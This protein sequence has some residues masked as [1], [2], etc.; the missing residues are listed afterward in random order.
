MTCCYCESDYENV[1]S[2]EEDGEC[3]Y[4]SEHGEQTET[5]SVDNHRRELPIAALVLEALVLTQLV[6]D[7]SQLAE[8]ALEQAD[9]RRPSA[10][11]RTTW[12]PVHHSAGRRLTTVYE[13]S[14]SWRA[15]TS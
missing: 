3:G 7:G 1:W 4:D 9:A 11:A 15:E 13:R 8:D 2:G 14:G 5:Q 12:N 6:C 10:T